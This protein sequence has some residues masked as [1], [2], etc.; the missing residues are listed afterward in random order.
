[1]MLAG[2]RL[3]DRGFTLTELLVV[4]AIIVLLVTILTPSLSQARFSAMRTKCGA[5]LKDVVQACIGYSHES[6]YSRGELYAALP[7][8]GPDNDNWGEFSKGNPGSLWLLMEHEF[9][10]GNVLLCPEAKGRL[11]KKAPQRGDSEFS[12][13][14][15]SYSYLSQV[16]TDEYDETG[17]PVEKVNASLV[18]LADLNP[19]CTPG[20]ESFSGSADDNSKSH[21]GDGQNVGSIDQSVKWISKP[22]E[23]GDNVY[24]PNSAGNDGNG[25]RGDLNDSYVCP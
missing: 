22:D 16:P 11:K 6:R 21:G 2:N 19:R 3:A 14:T 17:T 20:Q 9:I 4:I 1:M 24:A 8:T 5:N 15:Y 18:I 12:A 10:S 23:T 7:S 13:D 25:K